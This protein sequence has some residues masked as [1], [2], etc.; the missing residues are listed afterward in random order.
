MTKWTRK[1][2]QVL[3]RVRQIMESLALAKPGEW[4]NNADIRAKVATDSEINQIVGK[5]ID[6]DEA[7]RMVNWV[8]RGYSQIEGI[9]EANA[10]GQG[11]EEM[12]AAGVPSYSFSE[13]GMEA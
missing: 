3:Q 2:G 7:M 10:R 5:P 6:E 13:G 12:L 8:S 1:E 11:V 4:I 9:L